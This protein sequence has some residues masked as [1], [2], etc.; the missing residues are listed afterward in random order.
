MPEMEVDYN[1][2]SEQWLQGMQNLP[3]FSQIEKL[4][5]DQSSFCIEYIIIVS[6]YPG[7]FIVMF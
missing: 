5:V 2:K 4:K 6:L 7:T 1:S 3:I